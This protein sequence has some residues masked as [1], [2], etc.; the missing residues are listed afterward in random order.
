MTWKTGLRVSASSGTG[1]R[2]VMALKWDKH[3]KQLEKGQLETG[4]AKLDAQ[5][6]AAEL[7]KIPSC[8]HRDLRPL[9]GLWQQ[10]H[11]LEVARAHRCQSAITAPGGGA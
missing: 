11:P 3:A 8:G 10:D 9:S 2:S 1:F 6:D 5:I 4:V 7:K